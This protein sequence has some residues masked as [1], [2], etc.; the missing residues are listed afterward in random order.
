M[1]NFQSSFYEGSE[2]DNI[3]YVHYRVYLFIIILNFLKNAECREECGGADICKNPDLIDLWVAQTDCNI[4]CNSVSFQ[5]RINNLHESLCFE[6]IT[7][8]HLILYRNKNNIK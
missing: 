4:Q 8:F 7:S 3:A 6:I 2:L 1:R 5:L